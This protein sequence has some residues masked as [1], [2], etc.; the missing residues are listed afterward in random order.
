ML[1]KNTQ[2][3]LLSSLL[4]ILSSFVLTSQAKAAQFSFESGK[5]TFWDHSAVGGLNSSDGWEGGQ[6]QGTATVDGIT[7]TV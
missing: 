3:Y 5:G 2:K 6:T 1:F 7:L 4:F